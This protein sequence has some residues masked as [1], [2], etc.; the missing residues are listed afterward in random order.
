MEYREYDEKTLKQLQRLELMMLKDFIELCEKHHIDYFGCGGTAIGAVRHG[1]FIPWDDDID[2]GMTR[3]NYDRFLKVASFEMRDK[4]AILNAKTDRNYPFMITRWILRGTEFREEC[5]RNVPCKTGIFLDLYCFD[6]VADDDRAMKRQAWSAW[7]WAKLLILR[8]IP[9]PVLYIYGWKAALVQFMCKIGHWGLRLL[10]IS[11]EFLYKRAEKA[12][13][14]YKGCK[15][16]R[17]AF[18]FDPTPFTSVQ[19]LEDIEPTRTLPYEGMDVRFGNH[20]EE[21]LSVRYG[22]YMELPPEEKRHNHF[23]YRLDFGPWKEWE[24]DA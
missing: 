22:N 21:Y 15:T 5:L 13:K 23:P 10:H 3:E 18:F 2:I 24:Q 19:K 14:R 7:F 6:A 20:I 1:G 4:Y 16:K 8:S 9:T 11:P 12:A 17:V